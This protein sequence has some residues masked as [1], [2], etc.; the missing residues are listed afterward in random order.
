MN[1]TCVYIVLI[2]LLISLLNNKEEFYQTTEDYKKLYKRNC[3]NTT[4][5]LENVNMYENNTC[6][7][8]DV[9]HDGTMNNNR[10][11]CREFEDKQIY[12]KN[13]NKSWCKNVEEPPTLHN[14]VLKNKFLNLGK[15]NDGLG[16]D[17][18]NIAPLNANYPFD[19]QTF[20]TQTYD[21]K[22]DG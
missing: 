7:V 5:M 18:S 15:M 1:M 3:N 14:K 13:D 2:L 12:L 22:L 10:L 16:K 11:T 8:P 9:E 17:P 4:S 19:D 21:N 6:N 20:V